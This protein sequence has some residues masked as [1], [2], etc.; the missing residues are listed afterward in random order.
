MTGRRDPVLGGTTAAEV[1]QRIE[2]SKLETCSRCR[3]RGL[4]P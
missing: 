4:G 2:G 3:M 1:R